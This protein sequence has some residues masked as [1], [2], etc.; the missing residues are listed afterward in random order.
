MAKFARVFRTVH[1]N[2]WLGCLLLLLVTTSNAAENEL[3]EIRAALRSLSLEI[4]ALKTEHT[5]LSSRLR[6]TENQATTADPEDAA[7]SVGDHD[8]TGARRL[9]E[10]SATSGKASLDFNGTHLRMTA[11]LAVDGSVT[12]TGA[13]SG[14]SVMASGA[15]SG[16]SMTASGAVSG[17][18]M[19]ASGAVSGASVAA[20]GAITG[21]SLTTSG[22]VSASGAVSGASVTASGAVT[23]ASVA[24]SGAVSGASLTTTGAVSVGGDLTIS[25]NIYPS[26][27]I[28]FSATS[29]GYGAVAGYAGGATLPFN[30]EK[31]NLGGG[32]STSSYTF[33][34]P[35]SGVYSFS[36][37]VCSYGAYSKI[38][39]IIANNW[40]GVR[41]Y[42]ASFYTSQSFTIIR[43]M[44]A[45]QTARP[46]AIAGT[47]G[48]QDGYSAS[49]FSGHL[50]AAT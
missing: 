33:T 35:V 42:G 12:A 43:Q 36:V 39:F 2:R 47:I 10:D 3:T 48:L 18:S 37:F 32:Y 14:A 27:V 44:T 28:A 41:N 21:N 15:V 6:A 19:T 25:G 38:E 1:M 22:A 29:L 13:V 50:I 45:G 40:D 7:I 5:A 20:S 31:L 8:L 23:G 17:A 9:E 46:V 16:V 11:P 26:T 30:V 4:D 34:A 49:S 24:A